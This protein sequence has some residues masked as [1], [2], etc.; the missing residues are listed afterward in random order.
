MTVII[1][2]TDRL[3]SSSAV[4]ELLQIAQRE[5]GC[6]VGWVLVLQ[7]A[8]YFSMSTQPLGWQKACGVGLHYND[9][10]REFF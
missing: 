8:T 4:L 7:T 5:F 10:R 1:E 6:K 9:S 3:L 2:E